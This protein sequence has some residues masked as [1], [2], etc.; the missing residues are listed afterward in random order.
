MRCVLQQQTDV[1]YGILVATHASRIH[2][3][4][5]PVDIGID[6][7]TKP[8]DM[9]IERW[10]D[11]DLYGTQYVIDLAVNFELLQ[12]DVTTKSEE[13]TVYSLVMESQVH[14]VYSMFHTCSQEANLNVF[15]GAHS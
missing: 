3:V 5:V 4:S 15:L 13:S 9:E 1:Y 2:V 11:F 14:V 12:T 6:H 8:Q 7:A 10:L